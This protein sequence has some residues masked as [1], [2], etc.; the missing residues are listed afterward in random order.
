MADPLSLQ[1]QS[2]QFIPACPL[3][4]NACTEVGMNDAPARVVLRYYF[5]AGAGGLAVG[6]QYNSVF[7]IRDPQHGLIST[8]SQLAAEELINRNPNALR[9]G[10]I[11]G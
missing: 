1:L 2:G 9:I 4:L 7:A 10:G 11:C 5:D 3:A 6:V 8:C